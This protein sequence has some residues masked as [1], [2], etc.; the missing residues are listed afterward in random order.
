MRQLSIFQNLKSPHAWT[1]RFRGSPQKWLFADGEAVFAAV[2]EAEAHPVERP[3][4]PAKLKKVPPILKMSKLGAVTVPEDEEVSER[5]I[6]Q[7]GQ[8]AVTSV[9]STILE[10]EPKEANAHSEIQWLLLKLGSD[11]G[12]CKERQE[13]GVQWPVIC[14][15]SKAE[16]QPSPPV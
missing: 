16:R 4:D 9:T 3:F 5:E 8:R 11:M 1:G 15:Y 6:A 14:I 10:A 12:L 2:R 7:E 13:Q